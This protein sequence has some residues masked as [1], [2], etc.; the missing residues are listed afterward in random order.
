MACPGG[1][2]GGGGQPI[3]TTLEIAK[4]RAQGLYDLDSKDKF[5]KSHENPVVKQIYK[6]FLDTPLSK[7]SEKILHT[8]YT[9]RSEF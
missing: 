6:E 9:K 3:P 2:V 8:Y 7:K 5:R 4:K 1:C